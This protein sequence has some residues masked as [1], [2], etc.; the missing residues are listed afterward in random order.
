MRV[1]TLERGEVSFPLNQRLI[2]ELSAIRY[3][4]TP[5]GQIQ[6]EQKSETKK[7]VGH[8]PDLADAVALGFSAPRSGFVTSLVFP[9]LLRQG[10]RTQQYHWSV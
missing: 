9:R 4:Y 8:S 2:A 5:S 7:R 1:T 6:L 10:A 3:G